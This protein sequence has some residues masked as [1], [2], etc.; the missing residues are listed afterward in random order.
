MEDGAFSPGYWIKS[1]N[2]CVV[3]KKTNRKQRFLPLKR[4]KST[5]QKFGLI[6]PRY[7]D[8]DGFATWIFRAPG[9]SS[10]GHSQKTGRFLN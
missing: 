7:I 4:E 2:L 5:W 8:Q 3:R 10:G 9:S 6:V 1:G